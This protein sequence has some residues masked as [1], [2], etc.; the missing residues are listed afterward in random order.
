MLHHRCILGSGHWLEP[1][2][3]LTWLG[4]AVF[5]ADGWQAVAVVDSVWPR[6]CMVL[7]DHGVTV[8]VAAHWALVTA[9]PMFARALAASGAELLEVR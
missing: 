3:R 4:A 9:V 5:A 6:P 7:A 2:A 1:G 8:A